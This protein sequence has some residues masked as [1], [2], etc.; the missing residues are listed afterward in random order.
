MREHRGAHGGDRL[1]GAEG[2]DQEIDVRGIADVG[3]WLAVIAIASFAIVWF[4]YRGLSSYERRA[5]DAKP[6]PLQEAAAPR[7]PPGPQLQARPESDLAAFRAAERARL[8]GWGWIDASQRV[9][10]VPIEQAIE[11]VAANG[12]PDFAP[13]AEAPAP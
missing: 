6:S 1:G 4:F 12:L 3:V 13:P 9:A 5:L 7:V 8:N 11:S 10:H 2:I